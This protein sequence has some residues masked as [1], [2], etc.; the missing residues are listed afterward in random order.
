MA[1]EN[2]EIVRRAIDAFNGRDLDG[3]MRDTDPEVEVDWSRSRGVQA[4]IYRG[5]AAARGFW[6]T[7]FEMFERIVMSPDEFIESGE[8]VLVP[9]ATRLWGRDGVAVE[10]HSVYV[11]TLRNG[12]ILKWRLYQERPEA[13]EAVGLSEQDAHA[14]S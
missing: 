12:R 5:R 2:V 13:L 14:D 11:V 4:G 7:W 1:Q 3:A 6:N 8:H 10:A 9:N